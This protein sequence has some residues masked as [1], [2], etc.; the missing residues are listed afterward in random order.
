MEDNPDDIFTPSGINQ[1]TSTLKTTIRQLISQEI[2]HTLE[3][4]TGKPVV[5]NGL[6]SNSDSLKEDICLAYLFTFE[7]DVDEYE[8]TYHVPFA[9]AAILEHYCKEGYSEIKSKIN[10]EM[11]V[12]NKEI[13]LNL[14]NS[15]V[16]CLNAQQ[17]FSFLQDIELIDFH[18]QTV[19][20][21]K[22]KIIKNL[23]SFNI[24]IDKKEYELYLQLDNQFNKTF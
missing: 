4:Y 24:S 6:F 17:D 11:I 21:E 10:E 14:S 19:D 8:I 16:T 20:Y 5:G 12:A 7:T 22:I 2:N 23:Y 1:K 15:I 9:L 3:T 18:K 13:F